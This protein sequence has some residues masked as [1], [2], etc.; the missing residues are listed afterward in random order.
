MSSSTPPNTPPLPRS[1][2]QKSTSPSV[3]HPAAL[4]PGA[5]SQHTSP[6]SWLM[7][8]PLKSAMKPTPIITSPRLD[9]PDN[10][11]PLSPRGMLNAVSNTTKGAWWRASQALSPSSYQRLKSDGPG[12]FEVLK[13]DR[14]PAKARNPEMEIGAQTDEGWNEQWI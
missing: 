6:S 1:N 12:G 2:S 11:S 14:E 3:G 5:R 4:R 8:A 10:V 13:C 9:R 7:P